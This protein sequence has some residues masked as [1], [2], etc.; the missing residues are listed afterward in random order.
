MLADMSA[1]GFPADYVL[2]REAIVQNMT[3]ERIQ[4]LADQYLDTSNLVWL[5]VGDARTQ[6]ARLRSLGLG[7]PIVIDRQGERAR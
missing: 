5:V 1:Y 3:I 4:E 7:N 2:Q 6:R